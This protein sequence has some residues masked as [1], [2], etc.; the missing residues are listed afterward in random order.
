MIVGKG[1]KVTTFD[2]AKDPPSPADLAMAVLGPTGNLRA[3][4]LRI[5]K[6]W[7]VGFNEE[8]YADHFG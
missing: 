6:T 1:K 3:P 8:I 5:G 2:L 4:S 7:L